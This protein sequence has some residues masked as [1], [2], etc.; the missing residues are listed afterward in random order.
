M[1]QGAWILPQG[2]DVWYGWRCSQDV[3]MSSSGLV[4][5]VALCL[6]S[7][8]GSSRHMAGAGE[9]VWTVGLIS[10]CTGIDHILNVSPDLCELILYCLQVS[11]ST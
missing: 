1:G 9:A 2:G 4:V 3:V 8:L 5:T 7:F 11:R 6:R 10:V